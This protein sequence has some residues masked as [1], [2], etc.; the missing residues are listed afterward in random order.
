M[1]ES[2]L[3]RACSVLAVAW[4]LMA[5]AWFVALCIAVGTRDAK[6]EQLMADKGDSFSGQGT[7]VVQP[8]P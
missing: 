2:I 7:D 4:L 3:W 5:A 1:R 8:L 6:W